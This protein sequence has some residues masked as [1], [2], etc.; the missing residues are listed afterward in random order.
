[1]ENVERK[2]L[3]QQMLKEIELKEFLKEINAAIKDGD[4][5][6][7]IQAKLAELDGA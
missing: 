6:A 5:K 4:A 7:I 3:L 1:M 2:K